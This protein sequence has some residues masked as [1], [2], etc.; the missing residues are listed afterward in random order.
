VTGT[1]SRALH[2]GARVFWHA[3]QD[4]GGT[5]TAKDWAGV[6]VKWDSRGHQRILHNDMISVSAATGK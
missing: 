5:V 2:V 1:D 6:D 3:N 4:D